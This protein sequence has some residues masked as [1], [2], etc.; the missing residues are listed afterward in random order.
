MKIDLSMKTPAERV[1]F[2]IRTLLLMIC[3]T[4]FMPQGIQ[5]SPRQAM[6]DSIRASAMTLAITGINDPVSQL[7]K[8][9]NSEGTSLRGPG[10]R[11]GTAA[12][13]KRTSFTSP[14]KRQHLDSYA[15]DDDASPAILPSG[16]PLPGIFSLCAKEVFSFRLSLLDSHGHLLWY[17]LAP[18]ASRNA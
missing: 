17:A 13:G 11:P 5:N 1:S 6:D 2:V 18:P 12:S 16:T 8:L 7:Q 4:L 15:L 9:A 14:G 3:C 10:H